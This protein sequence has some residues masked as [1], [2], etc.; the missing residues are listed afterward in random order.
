MV[1]INKINWIKS[2]IELNQL[3]FKDITIL[4]FKHIVISSVTDP[5]LFY[6]MS[7]EE[8]SVL[9]LQSPGTEHIAQEDTNECMSFQ[10]HCYKTVKYKYNGH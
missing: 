7:E 3:A 6:I 9:F 4:S 10:L 8:T 1:E 5:R 2:K